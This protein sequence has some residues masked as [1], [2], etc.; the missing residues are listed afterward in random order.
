[1]IKNK[2]IGMLIGGGIGDVLGSQNENL[3][4][5][6]INTR[7]VK[8]LFPTSAR[9][10]DDTEMTLVLGQHLIEE[11]GTINLVKLHKSYKH[12]INNG[13]RG[14][15]SKTRS[16]L[17]NYHEF[18]LAGDASTNGAI[19]R[20]SPLALKNYTVDCELTADIKQAIYCTHGH[21]KDAIDTAYVYV[22]ILKALLINRFSTGLEIYNYMLEVAARTRNA[23]LFPI[24]KLTGK[25]NFK[26]Q[27]SLTS[28][29][30]GFEL[31]QIEAIDCLA[32]AIFCF[33]FNFKNPQQAIIMAANCGGDTDTI[34]KLTGELVGAQNGIDW[35]P[36]EW[37]TFEGRHQLEAMALKLI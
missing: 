7:G 30:F 17:G 35:I 2:C 37:K 32:C 24:L 11:S 19:M 31:F 20:I 33:L 16:I 29:L 14:Y 27:E 18:V 5:N 10:T 26:K 9:Y 34:A 1:M 36:T 3:T 6:E 23:R 12:A 28:Q 4:F 15:S 21:S 25:I 8:H 13:S 22:K